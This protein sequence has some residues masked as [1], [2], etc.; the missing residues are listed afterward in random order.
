MKN[1]PLYKI[2]LINLGT[3]IENTLEVLLGEK[4]N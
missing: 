3:Q 1:K 2:K 4:K